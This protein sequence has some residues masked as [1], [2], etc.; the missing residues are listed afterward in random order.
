[1]SITVDNSLPRRSSDGGAS[2]TSDT[3]NAVTNDLI[4]A[5]GNLD[6]NGLAFVVPTISNNG[7]A[8]TWTNIANIGA[9]NSGTVCAWFTILASDRSGLTVTLT[10]GNTNADS[11]SI[12]IY[13]L[14]GHDSA[15]VL[16]AIT[17][18]TSNTNNLTTA[19]ITPETS[20][21][22][23]GIGTDWDQ[24]GLPTSSDLTES[25]FDTPGDISGLAG[26]KDLT[27]GVAATANMDAA[28]GLS[29]A[30]RYVWFEIRAAVVAVT[31]IPGVTI[32]P[33]RAA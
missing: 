23:F 27:A 25:G 12:K 8:L 11:P 26:F 28:G 24:L 29:A 14:Q 21:V 31:G 22:G 19:S 17:N 13:L 20:G 9:S 7:A 4:L 33:Y 16:G 10:R 5:C 2:I 15:D 3:F 18:N 32:A 30:W 1:M 6:Q